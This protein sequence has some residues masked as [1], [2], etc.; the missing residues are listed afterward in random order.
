VCA[1]RELFGRFEGIPYTF[2]REGVAYLVDEAGRSSMPRWD[3]VGGRA[4]SEEV[5]HT[6]RDAS[7]CNQTR[8]LPVR[9]DRYPR[10]EE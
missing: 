6:E 1:I 9:T 10:F 4:A 5:V 2:V 7:N 8:I 3:A